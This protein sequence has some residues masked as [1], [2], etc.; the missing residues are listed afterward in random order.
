MSVAG[1]VGEDSSSSWPLE[2]FQIPRLPLNLP[3]FPSTSVA[4]PHQNINICYSKHH[5]LICKES[6]VISLP[7]VT[8]CEPVDYPGM[9][10]H[11]SVAIHS[12]ELQ[13][14]KDKATF[15]FICLFGI[16]LKSLGRLVLVTLSILLIL[17]RLYHN[18]SSF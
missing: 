8:L 17:K 5:T 1:L 7:V 4:S 6:Y 18:L 16:C 9:W 2:T 10:C 3:P 11:N 12:T 15:F 14:Q 13:S